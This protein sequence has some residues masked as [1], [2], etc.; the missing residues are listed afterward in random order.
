MT[1]VHIRFNNIGLLFDGSAQIVLLSVKFSLSAV[2]LPNVNVNTTVHVNSRILMDCSSSP[3][4][5]KFR[6]VYK[7][8]FS[9]P[10]ELLV[11]RT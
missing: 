11:D 5:T 6:F 3:G 1:Y 2:G 9:S 4:F 8:F 7:S 10:E